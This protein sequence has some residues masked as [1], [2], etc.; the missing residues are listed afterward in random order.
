MFGRLGTL[1]CHR[2]LGLAALTALI[3]LL[4]FQFARRIW[5]IVENGGMDCGNCDASPA[6]FLL[7]WVIEAAVL[8]LSVWIFRR[9]CGRSHKENT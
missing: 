2:S 5:F 8:G 9:L 3:G 4:L 7:G 1:N 6:G